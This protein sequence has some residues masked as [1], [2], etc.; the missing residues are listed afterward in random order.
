M[1]QF[2]AARNGNLIW[3]QYQEEYGK[4]PDLMV[5][6]LNGM[7]CH[8]Y[9][10]RNGH[11]EVVNF[12]IEDCSQK[13]QIDITTGHNRP[14]RSAAENGHLE[15]V[16]YLLEESSQK[17][18]IDLQNDQGLMIRHVLARGHVTTLKYF[19]EDCPDSMNFSINQDNFDGFRAA[20]RN[21]HSATVQYLIERCPQRD[22]INLTDGDNAALQM[23]TSQS[24]GAMF[25]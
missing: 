10:C 15:V 17:S 14:I 18:H 16:K 3:F 20:I 4:L 25:D 2:K 21:G 9:A 12:L 24:E 6:E 11:L 7:Y 23:V 1:N 22:K 5:P 19:L 13:H 8:D